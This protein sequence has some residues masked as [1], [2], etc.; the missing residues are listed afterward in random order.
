MYLFISSPSISQQPTKLLLVFVRQLH[1]YVRAPSYPL[2]FFFRPYD[3]TASLCG[4]VELVEV[5]ECGLRVL[6]LCACAHRAVRVAYLLLS[7]DC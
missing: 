1:G 5:V 7:P 6:V 2:F 4:T 3:G